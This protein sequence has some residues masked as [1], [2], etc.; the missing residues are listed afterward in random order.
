M[1]LE[2][3]QPRRDFSRKDSNMYERKNNYY[4]SKFL[5]GVPQK[6]DC[7]QY[8]IFQLFNIDDYSNRGHGGSRTYHPSQKNY[9]QDYRLSHHE[10]PH[11][12]KRQQPDSKTFL[13]SVDNRTVAA[14]DQSIKV[15]VNQG[16]HVNKPAVM[17][18]KGSNYRNRNALHSKSEK[19]KPKRY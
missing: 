11:E 19:Q 16:N 10:Q 9:S 8:L 13:S 7:I 4:E 15:T 18:V 6:C 5:N 2:K 1:S 17:S 3:E 12:F 14:F